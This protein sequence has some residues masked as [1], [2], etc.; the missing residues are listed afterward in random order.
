M[1]DLLLLLRIYR[2]QGRYTEASNVLQRIRELNFQGFQNEW[3]IVRQMIELFELTQ[4]WS[5]LY[6][7]CQSILEDA[8][9]AVL[10]PSNY[11]GPW[12]KIAD[13]WKVWDG[14]ITASGKCES[15][16]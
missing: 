2:A 8:L 4:S 5:Y 15:A 13:D 3:E 9:T 11:T 16:E 14:F 12:G 6:A 1:Q 7:L 10:D